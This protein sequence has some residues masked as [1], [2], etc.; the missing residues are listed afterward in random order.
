[1]FDKDENGTISTDEVKM[2]LGFGK[3]FSENIWKEIIREVDQNSDGKVSYEEFS[4]M[5]NKFLSDN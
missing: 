2:I 4:S 5:M 1:L 3:R